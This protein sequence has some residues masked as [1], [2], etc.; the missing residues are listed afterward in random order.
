MNDR[1]L[2]VKDLM[3]IFSVSRSTI[4][5]WIDDEDFPR[6]KRLASNTVRWLESDVTKWQEEAVME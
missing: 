1:L 3:Q 6:G 5:R 4:Y 2:T